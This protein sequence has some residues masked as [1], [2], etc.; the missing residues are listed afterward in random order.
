MD[1]SEI[2]R[3]LMGS[4]KRLHHTLFKNLFL[5][6]ATDMKPSPL[7]LMFRLQKAARDG[8]P[9]LRVSDIAASM[10]IS[11]PGITQIVTGLEKEGLVQR[12]MDPSD[13]RAVLVSATEEGRK[14]MGPAYGRLE[15]QFIGLI[16]H[17]G[18]KDSKKLMQLL[19]TLE[20]YFEE[21]KQD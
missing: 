2:A 20:N 3:T 7:F 18:E 1:K 16:E 11:V 13:R 12:D 5:G 6:M 19:N 4:F 10:G 15:N 8:K 9:G 17:L 21:K 14:M